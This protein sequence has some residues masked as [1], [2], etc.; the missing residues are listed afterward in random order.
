MID[1]RSQQ[2]ADWQRHPGA[3][4]NRR[5][6]A[7]RAAEIEPFRV[8][9]I[10]GHAQALQA[11]GRDVIHLKVGEPDFPT[12]PPIVK[13][14]IRALKAGQ[15]RY[16]PAQGL[17]ELRRHRR[18]LPPASWG[19]SVACAHRRHTR[20]LWRIAPGLGRPVRPR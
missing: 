12:P 11:E 14:G 4:G 7:L 3:Y 15:T 20:C 18:I 1:D 19:D 8:M 17:P 5:P 6:S 10:L 16:T 2:T 13:A 9:D